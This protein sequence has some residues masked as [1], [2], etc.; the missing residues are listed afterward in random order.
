MS[1]LLSLL[2]NTHH[3][4]DLR[5][6]VPSSGVI[7]NRSG[8][9]SAIAESMSLA[10]TLAA[11]AANDSI[12]FN[13]AVDKLSMPVAALPASTGAWTATFWVRLVVA[14]TGAVGTLWS[15]D[16]PGSSTWHALSVS[17]V[18]AVLELS[19]GGAP[20]F[21]LGALTVGTWYFVAVRKSAANAVKGYIGAEAPGALTTVT[22]TVSNIAT[23]GKGWIGG[24][25]YNRWPNV[26]MAH[27]RLWNVELTD[28]EVQAERF[29]RTAV[30]TSGLTASWPLSDPTSPGVDLAGSGYTLTNT[31]GS[32]T[33]EQ[34]P[35]FPPLP[36]AYTAAINEALA[37]SESINVGTPFYAALAESIALASTVGSTAHFHPTVSEILALTGRVRIPGPLDFS[38]GMPHISLG[39]PYFGTGTPSQM[40]DNGYGYTVVTPGAWA[41]TAGSWVAVEVGFGPTDV[42]VALSNDQAGGTGYLT[43]VFAA[44]HIDVSADSTNGVDNTWTTV[45]TVTGNTATNRAHKLAFTGY[46]WVKLVCDTISGG[47]LDELDIWDASNGT[48]DTFAFIGDSITYAAISRPS[49]TGGGQRPSFQDDVLAN[50]PGHYPLQSN[51]GIIGAG[52]TDWASGIG[53]ALA[54]FPNTK[55]WCITVGTNDASGMPGNIAAFRSNMTTVINAITAAG[56]V[57]ILARVP[58]TGAGAYGGGDYVTCGLRY[59]NDN[60]IDYLCDTLNVRPGPDLYQLFYDNGAAFN[61]LAD[62]HPNE[63]GSKAWTLTWANS[64]SANL[65][66]AYTAAVAETLSL[67]GTLTSHGVFH[68]TLTETVTL[69]EALAAVRRVLASLAETVAVSDS[70]AALRRVQLAL[71]ETVSLSD[72]ITS[73]GVFRAS[74]PDTVA[75]SGALGALQRAHT[76]LAESVTL[77]DATTVAK[78]STL[79]LIEGLTIGESLAALK[80]ATAQLSETVTLS[81]SLSAIKRATAALAETLTLAESIATAIA[82][83]SLHYTAVLTETLALAEALTGH[84]AFH[85]AVTDS[86]A[87]SEVL[88]GRLHL[89]S[90]VNEAVTLAETLI[91]KKASHPTLA[92]T[93]TL[94]EA[95]AAVLKAKV[96]LAETE[97]LA[98]SLGSKFAAHVA[99]ADTVALVESLLAKKNSTQALADTVPL[100]ETLASR[101]V[102]HST[103]TDTVPLSDALGAQ[104]RSFAAVSDAVALLESIAAKAGTRGAVAETV[105]LVSTV[106]ASRKAIAA[107]TETV[108]LA[109]LQGS[110][111]VMHQALTDALA[112]TDAVLTSTAST[113]HYTAALSEIVTLAEQLVTRLVAHNNLTDTVTLAGTLTPQKRSVV[114]AAES[115]SLTDA[116]SSKYAGHLIVAETAALSESLLARKAAHPLLTESLVLSDALASRFRGIS[117]LADTVPFSETL[118]SR[119]VFKST[120]V[121]SFVLA[122]ALAAKK[123]STAGLAE[124]LGLSEAF[125]SKAAF[126][127][128]LANS[129]TL[130]ELLGVSRHVG[131]ALSE[132]LS[133]GDTLL[134]FG[135]HYAALLE[136]ALLTE[137]QAT[138]YVTA[139]PLS[140]TLSLAESLASFVGARSFQAQLS[141][142]VSF[143]ESVSADY[144]FYLPFPGTG[145]TSGYIQPPTGILVSATGITPPLTPPSGTATP[146]AL[147]APVPNKATFTP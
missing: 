107:L 41:A 19:D 84:V 17:D 106:A 105:A 51:L 87:L 86:V 136:T 146:G 48:P 42:L 59:L 61:V 129:V 124:T 21:N 68:S 57:P 73:R 78:K 134:P 89:V 55:Y 53:A 16:D 36:A 82:S 98:E 123:R 100:T 20:A 76:A 23:Y 140:D 30:K 34:G 94:S 35:A 77:S 116:L 93:V 112:L 45:L 7:A 62:P 31:G 15:F 75:L 147:D 9:H 103:L 11:A 43:T 121:E 101:G 47:Q 96:A 92:E 14:P 110:R 28:A 141:E 132:N 72:A 69:S 143:L 18:G 3:T 120:L 27:A 71:P 81:E 122:E 138:K 80:R 70:I 37:L 24:D 115:L 118:A 4:T 65:F 6:V 32:W 56:R 79:S 113:G 38:V 119:G 39:K 54:M 145:A 25:N 64:V 40:F 125:F 22:G 117:V 52:S 135:R 58:W 60:G 26:R 139:V 46:K 102:F 144:R 74:L 130:A 44:Y 133:L 5:D 109:E 29:S 50:Q 83:G 88:L 8:V 137:A 114:A 104:K 99:A 127:V 108:T 67:S 97:T 90:P 128:P 1:L 95:L 49:Y 66:T 85:T 2:T 33:L 12:R 142:V 91:A 13:A 131:A 111:A 63:T 126:N 10:E